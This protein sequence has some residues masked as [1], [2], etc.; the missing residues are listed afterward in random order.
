MTLQDQGRILQG[1][2]SHFRTFLRW[3]RSAVAGLGAGEVR[4]MARKKISGLGHARGLMAWVGLGLAWL[5]LA[6]MPGLTWASV[7]SGLIAINNNDTYATSQTVY[8]TL[9]VY[10]AKDM[11]FSNDNVNWGGWEACSTTSEYTGYVTTTWLLSDG[12]GGK[13][14]YAQLR[15]IENEESSVFSDGIFLDANAP[16]GSVSINSGAEY[17]NSADVTLTFTADDGTG[18]GVDK[19]Y[20]ST[21]FEG[22][23]TEYPYPANNTMSYTLPTGDGYKIVY[24]RFKDIAGNISSKKGSNWIKL[25][26]APPYN[27]SVGINGGGYVNSTYV[28]LTLDG[29]DDT[30]GVGQMRLSNDNS[31]WTGW[32]NFSSSK[33]WGLSDGDGPKTVYAQFMDN[34]GNVSGVVSGDTILDT[35]PPSGSVV[36]N[37]N[38][39]YAG[40]TSVTLT[41]NASD[42]GS[43]IAGMSFSNDGTNWSAGETYNTTKAWTLSAGDGAKTVYAMFTDYAG[44]VSPATKDTIIL[45]TGPP[46]ACA[47]SINNG[48]AYTGTTAVTLTLTA[49][50]AGSGMA[51]GKVLLSNNGA[52]YTES[53]FA[54]TKAWTLASGEGAK[55]V[56][57]KFKDA[58][59]N[60]TATAVT[61]TIIL[62]T[63]PPTG[64]LTINGGAQYTTSVQ[65]TAELTATDKNGIAKVYLSN[66]QSGWTGY[67]MSN[68]LPWNLA[69]GDGIKT[70]SARFEDNAGNLSAPVQASIILDTKPPKGTITINGGAASTNSAQVS[71]SLKADDVNGLAKVYLSNGGD[72]WTALP[73][74]STIPWSLS[75]G[76]G[77][78]TVSAIFEDKA[79]LTCAAQ[80]SIILDSTGPSGN[81]VINGNAAYAT[82]ATVTL[83]LSA[84]DSLSGVTGMCFSNDGSNFTPWEG[85]NLS[86][87]W[88]L[89]AGSGTKR[90]YAK[91]RDGVLNAGKPVSNTIILDTQAPTGTI[92]I[93]G[94]AAYT[95]TV[96]VVADLT[97]ADDTSVTGVHLSNDQKGWTRYSMGN[98]L[99]W[100]LTSGDGKKTVYA[101]FEDVVGRMSAPVQAAIILD[102]KPPKGTITINGGAAY[103]NSA[104]VSLSLKADDVNG[105]AK[106][107]LSNG[108]DPW[109]ELPLSST[110]PWSLSA[111]D[112]QKTVSAIFEDKAG[113]TFAAQ[114]SII[115]DTAAPTGTIT[116]QG[117]AAYTKTTAVTLNLSATDGGSGL[118]KMQFSNDNV[119]WSALENFAATKAWT[120]TSGDGTKTVYARFT[121][122]AGNVSGVVRD[123]IILASTLVS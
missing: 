118:S 15:G 97:A 46:T 70:V 81:I 110:I 64:T 91:F 94:G 6:L 48:A 43:G 74:S 29:T 108:G 57:A 72:P 60:V 113:L 78:K 86:K 7:P 23:D 24:A 90:V 89:T 75:A 8:L 25:D 106:V 39:T 62:D 120:L 68:K 96:Q 115:L 107:Y 19:V 53:A 101:R 71:L 1:F 103:T 66:S 56:Y 59:G 114:A 85:F 123:S 119:T 41:L 61:A 47:V 35:V 17:T 20:L 2:A 12:D 14:V 80:D 45:D 52:T 99:P 109:T 40:S 27:C 3:G 51:G 82:S 5:C 4:V 105:L 116:I 18:S 21:D 111:G 55:T 58:A 88:S 100:N 121:D 95:N 50:D 37:N 11:R 36:I 42:S 83:T 63:G 38:D 104:Q 34:A 26:T 87:S 22:E 65:V 112:G 67:P 102:T 73:M 10:R 31:S 9:Y 117:G 93:N 76:D 13:T 33:I 122:E 84:D 92:A 77:Q 54:A 69:T 16:A 32:M 28:Y 44:N 49:T 30:S 79:G 98:Q